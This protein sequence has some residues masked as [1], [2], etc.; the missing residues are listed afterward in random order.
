[1]EY[2]LS[3]FFKGFRLYDDFEL[4]ERLTFEKVTISSYFVYLSSSLSIYLQQRMVFLVTI[5]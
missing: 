4:E 5:T 3:E 2:A 1:M